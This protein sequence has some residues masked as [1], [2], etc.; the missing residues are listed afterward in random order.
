MRGK[1]SQKGDTAP[2]YMGND[3]CGMAYR[4]TDQRD[5]YV[6]PGHLIDPDGA[7]SLVREYTLHRMPEPI[8]Q[9]HILSKRMAREE[10][11]I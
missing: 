10:E 6:S 3:L 9:A 4:S 8:R 2:I 5:I 1:L 11:N 7:L